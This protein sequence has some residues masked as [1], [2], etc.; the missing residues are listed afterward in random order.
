MYGLVRDF[1]STAQLLCAMHRSSTT[2]GLAACLF[3]FFRRY[4]TLNPRLKDG[5]GQSQWGKGRAWTP[6]QSALLLDVL[7]E[8]EARD[9][10]EISWSKI[11]AALTLRGN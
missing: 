2:Y 5:G 6:A 8:S 4:R 3:P 11:A 10:S 7:E 1:T 9:E